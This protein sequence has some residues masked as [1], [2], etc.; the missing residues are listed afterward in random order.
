MSSDDDDLSEKMS[1]NNKN[2]KK[3]KKKVSK[4]FDKVR[5]GSAAL[6]K[7][8]KINKSSNLCDTS[9]SMAES[10][11]LDEIK[12]LQKSLEKTVR[13]ENETEAKTPLGKLKPGF[14]PNWTPETQILD[15]LNEVPNV[16]IFEK[17]E[18]DIS[19]KSDKLNKT[20]PEPS[21]KTNVLPDTQNT[22]P[23]KTLKSTDDLN[24]NQFAD[25]AKQF[26][27]IRVKDTKTNG[28]ALLKVKSCSVT[29]FRK[30]DGNSV[31]GFIIEGVDETNIVKSSYFLPLNNTMA[32]KWLQIVFK[33]QI[34]VYC[35]RLKADDEKTE[36]NGKQIDGNSVGQKINEWYE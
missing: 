17:G 26:K 20:S 12:K 6:E 1:K 24:N 32:S 15:N 10:K 18:E 33:R 30:C 31:S 2:P 35:E 28:E 11:R 34:E 22:P 14:K 21:I 29:G 19:P 13:N 25:L 5:A 4:Q 27:K 36:I 7:F 8:K 23:F 3:K 9:E 16:E